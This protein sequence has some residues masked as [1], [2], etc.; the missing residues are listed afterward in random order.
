MFALLCGQD[1][2]SG[3]RS[4]SALSI[5]S[6]GQGRILSAWNFSLL[7]QMLSLGAP[8]RKLCSPVGIFH[9]VSEC[10]HDSSRR[11]SQNIDDMAVKSSSRRW[12]LSGEPIAIAPV[13]LDVCG[14][15]RSAC[16]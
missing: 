13:L 9:I 12:S 8:T 5:Q 15:D 10:H 11:L 7:S 14:Q 2:S 16:N 3:T 1:P 4:L 6:E